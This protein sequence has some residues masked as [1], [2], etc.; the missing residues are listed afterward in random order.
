MPRSFSKGLSAELQVLWLADCLL[1]LA[2]AF[3]ACLFFLAEVSLVCGWSETVSNSSW[4]LV[5]LETAPSQ[6][7][8]R[9]WYK[10]LPTFLKHVTPPSGAFGAGALRLAGRRFVWYESW[11]NYLPTQVWFFFSFY[12]GLLSNKLNAPLTPP[13]YLFPGEL[14]CD[15]LFYEKS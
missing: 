7:L 1:L 5:L 11:S 13:Q 14:T 3:R 10:T 15:I 8:N 6:W 2:H 12:M 4:D 9:E